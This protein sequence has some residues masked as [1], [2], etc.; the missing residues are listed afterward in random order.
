PLVVEERA[1]AFDGAGPQRAE[2]NEVAAVQWQLRDLRRV[3]DLPERGRT[4]IDF[5]DLRGAGDG[6]RF[7]DGRWLQDHVEL[8]VLLRLEA[9]ALAFGRPE[10]RE[11]D[12][13]RVAA[14][15]QER[16]LEP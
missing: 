11:R 15:R 9:D 1:F 16:E 3:D 8:A 12:L 7:L 14:D 2:L 13:D 10:S 6:Q 5:D 4:A